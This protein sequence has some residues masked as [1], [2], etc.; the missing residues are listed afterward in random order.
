V[1]NY[2][3]DAGVEVYCGA[4]RNGTQISV[5]QYSLRIEAPSGIVV[6]VTDTLIT[7]VAADG[8]I[9]TTVGT[10]FLPYDATAQEYYYN[11]D[12][13]ESGLWSYIWHTDNPRGTKQI[14]FFVNLSDADVAS[15]P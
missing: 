7:T 13:N 8:T 15:S 6:T 5:N 14:R 11:I 2:D 10:G 4:Y 3:K 1:N 12:A 9:A